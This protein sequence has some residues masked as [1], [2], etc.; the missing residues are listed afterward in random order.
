MS[1]D[2]EQIELERE[3]Q[4]EA[5]EE[6]I[7]AADSSLQADDQ[8]GIDVEV[9]QESKTVLKLDNWSMR[10]GEE[11]YKDSKA[12]RDHIKAIEGDN[13][14]AGELIAA[15]MFSAAFEPE[16]HFADNPADKKRAE[17]MQHMTQTTQF[18]QLKADTM[19]DDVASEIAATSF[20][21]T[22]KVLVV[23]GK[24]CKDAA[25]EAMENAGEDVKD[26]KDM[27]DS[28]GGDGLGGEGGTP[29][30]KMSAKR[31]MELLKKARDSR[32]LKRIAQLAGK[33]RRAAQSMQRR[34][35]I[36]G[37]DDTVGVTVGGDVNKLI[38]SELAKLACGDP[39][40]EDL[41]TIKIMERRA[42]IREHKGIEN[43]ARGPIVVV[44]DESG[45]MSGEPICQAKAIALAMYW[46]AKQQNR[47]CCLVGFSGGTEGTYLA[48]PPGDD[49]MN[50]VFEWCEHFYGGGTTCDVPLIELPRKWEKLGCPKGKTDMLIITDAIVHCPTEVKESFNVWKAREQCKVST[51]VIGRGYH[52]LPGDDEAGDLSR[53]SD[54]VH[55]VNS[56]D[57]NT[58]GEV[59]S[60]FEGV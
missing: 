32:H 39:D 19:L 14:L 13:E 53:I 5:F 38:S 41:Q 55:M 8:V 10:R 34:K 30:N 21:A 17:F 11:V 50:Q 18:E 43:V 3:V 6:Q 4:R 1:D 40:I 9:T 37:M 25:R 52:V 26:A 48:L 45:S 46:V 31:T 42:I 27:T 2:T 60:V 54:T 16:L 36:H 44:V 47:W 51:L 58:G 57:L 29:G 49:K 24:E 15:D 28:F 20:A 12:L 35:V 59:E 7:T 33:Y 56:L 23:E 22:Y